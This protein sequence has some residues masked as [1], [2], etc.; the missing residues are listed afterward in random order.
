MLFEQ[1]QL[2]LFPSSFQ[3]LE[4]DVKHVT[5]EVKLSQALLA[6][7]SG[8]KHED[9]MLLED[10]LDCLKER[11]GTLGGALGQRLDHLRTRAHNLT[12][13]QVQPLLYS[14][15]IFKLYCTEL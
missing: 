9:R 10:N 11:L 1:I 8:L 12:A 14:F 7:S 4:K 13:Y 6:G 15:H 3:I 2:F 5:E